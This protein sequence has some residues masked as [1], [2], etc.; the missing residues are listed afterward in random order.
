M[1]F[2]DQGRVVNR[3]GNVGFNPAYSTPEQMGTRIS[4]GKAAYARIVKER[5]IR[6]E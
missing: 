4:E 5:Q 6:V 1:K 2:L 3:L